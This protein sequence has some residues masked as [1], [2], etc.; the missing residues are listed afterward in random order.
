MKKEIWKDV[1]AYEGHYMV[2]NLGNVKSFKKRNFGKI[3]TATKTNK[4]YKVVRLSDGV[5][6]KDRTV[7]QLVAEAFLNHKVNGRFII[8]DHINNIKDDNR[9][10]NL[11]IITARENAS[12]DKKNKTSKYTG[13]SWDRWKKKWKATIRVK[14][15]HLFLGRFNTE[16]EAAAVYNDKIKE[17]LHNQGHG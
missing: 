17:V 6:V 16:E 12:K 10:E 2:S 3:L 13:V 14:K 1:V 15:E 5:N 8:V 11:Q 7:H 4:G 9:L